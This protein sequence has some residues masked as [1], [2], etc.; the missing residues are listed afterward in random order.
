M[1]GLSLGQ[2]DV[3]LT[4]K[5]DRIDL[6]PDGS[7]IIY[8]YKTGAPP[9]EKVQKHFDRQLPLEA[10]IV[11]AGGFETLGPRAIHALGYISFSGEGREVAV[12]VSPDSLAKQLA[13]LRKLLSAYAQEDQ[14]YTARRAPS[15]WAGDYDHLA[16]FGEWDDT[17]EIVT[18]KVGR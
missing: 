15:R 4:A 8:D 7:V 9:S 11:Q 18:I 12:D 6:C 17:S 5:A 2:P 1:G 10:L 14:G 13:D 16:R 3:M